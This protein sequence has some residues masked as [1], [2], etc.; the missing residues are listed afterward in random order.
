MPLVCSV[1]WQPDNTSTLRY[2]FSIIWTRARARSRDSSA[3]YYDYT[4]AML[5]RETQ[6]AGA[7][8]HAA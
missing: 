6:N 1:A 4:A 2:C 3:A 7:V 8:Y 5:E